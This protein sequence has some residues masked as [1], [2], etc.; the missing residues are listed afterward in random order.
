MPKSMKGH[1]PTSGRPGLVTGEDAFRDTKDWLNPVALSVLKGAVEKRAKR[2]HLNGI[3][4]TIEY[5]FDFPSE[6]E[7]DTKCVRLKRVD[8]E[9]A[10][11]GYVSY[12]RLRKFDFETEGA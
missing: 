9:F 8:G 5:D 2:V 11:M 12:K 7:E 3:E 4:Y 10:P 6:Y 1:D